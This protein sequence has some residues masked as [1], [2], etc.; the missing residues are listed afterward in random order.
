MGAILTMSLLSGLS[1]PV[2]ALIVTTTPR[3]GPRLLAAMLGLASGVMA[4]VTVLDLFPLAWREGGPVTAVLGLLLGAAGMWTLHGLVV[5]TGTADE[6]GRFRMMGWFVAAAMALHDLPE[7]MAIG[8]GSVVGVRVGALLALAIAL[9]NVP[10]GMSIAAPLRMGHVASRRILLAT[11]L[12]GF[13]TPAGTALA[14]GV[15]AFSPGSSAVI[16]ALAAGAMTYVVGHDTLPASVRASG[17]AALLGLA[18]GVVLMLVV[19]IGF[20][21]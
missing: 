2:G 16:L 5:G 10:E 20:R 18:A 13:V 9:H 4:V 1:T 6:Q 21:M 3:F 19:H 8:A 15:G 12:I 7:G 11:S 17:P 14:L